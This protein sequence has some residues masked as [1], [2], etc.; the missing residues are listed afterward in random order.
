MNTPMHFPN[1][2]KILL[3]AA[4]CA[5]PLPVSAK[6]LKVF[7]LAGQANMA[8]NAKVST[9][10]AIGVD[11]ETAPM[12][13]EMVRP[14][15]RP[16]VM[17]EVWISYMTLAK[18][19]QGFQT[20]TGR[21]TA[22]FGVQKDERIGPEFT[23]GIYIHKALN[24]PI[25]IIKNAWGGRSL[26]TDFRPPSAGPYEFTD[27]QMREMKNNG[28]DLEK[29]KAAKAQETGVFY[30]RLIKHVEDV[31]ADPKQVVPSYDP[32]EGYEL[33]GFVW[34]Q[35]W[36]DLTDPKVY[37]ERHRPGGYK[38]Y[39]ENL[40][41]FIRDVRKDLD[42]PDMPF[43]IGVMGANGEMAPNDRHTP[44]HESFRAAMAAPAYMVEFKGNVSAVQTSGFWDHHLEN[45][46]ERGKRLKDYVDKKAA[47][48]K[49]SAEEKAQLMEEKVNRLF[50]EDDRV[51]LRGGEPQNYHYLSSAK[52]LGQIGKA[53][54]E[55]MVR[56]QK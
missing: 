18:N 53:F 33:A 41:H 20:K 28:Q 37:P 22:G 30:R 17:E 25:L 12:L 11:P 48:E 1:T 35:G 10:D 55:E 39:T 50:S 34:F 23:F 2:L 46:L 27:V 15:G 4:L 43:V 6:P 36:N 54:A 42:A 3:A 7:I 26:H 19:P 32:A 9:F 5:A 14:S 13:K 52:I 45:V 44:I 38:K 24:E 49:L 47:S 31:L 21:L 40:V 29:A 56:L 51:L 8:G 16:R